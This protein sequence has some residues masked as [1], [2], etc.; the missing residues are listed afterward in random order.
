MKVFPSP[1][2]PEKKAGRTGALWGAGGETELGL[3]REIFSISMQESEE[4]SFPWSLLLKPLVIS[5]VDRGLEPYLI[6]AVS[7]TWKVLTKYLL[8][9]G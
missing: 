9:L 4:H 6:S 8:A 3:R 7:G 2:K 1:V 5:F